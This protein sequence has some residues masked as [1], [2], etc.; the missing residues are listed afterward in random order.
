MIVCVCV[1]VCVC[2]CERE[3]E[4]ERDRERHSIVHMS[5]NNTDASDIQPYSKIRRQ[6]QRQR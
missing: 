2:V 4:R 5:D 1:H 3:R 6:M